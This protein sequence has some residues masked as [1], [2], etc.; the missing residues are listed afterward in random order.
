MADLKKRLAEPRYEPTM[1]STAACP[2]TVASHSPGAAYTYARSDFEVFIDQAANDIYEISGISGLKSARISAHEAL[3]RRL[4]GGRIDISASKYADFIRAAMPESVDEYQLDVSPPVKI[5]E[6]GE[7]ITATFIKKKPKP[8][9]FRTLAQIA[10]TL[11]R[12]GKS[13]KDV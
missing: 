6:A 13:N 11:R 12:R 7:P 5:V 8:K 4:I 9:L 3:K 2:A 1:T 10:S